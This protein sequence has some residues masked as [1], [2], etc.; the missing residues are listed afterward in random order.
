MKQSQII[1]A[2][3]ALGRLTAQEW[4]VKTA[5]KL[6]LIQDALEPA[7]K[8]GVRM[9]E[10]LIG[11]YGGVET[12]RGTF[13]FPTIDEQKGFQSA[14]EELLDTDATV[15]YSPLMIKDGIPDGLTLRPADM[16]ALDGVVNF[17]IQTE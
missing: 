12:E 11:Q 1:G 5:Y 10:K 17:D 6:M 16:R 15:I 2:Y 8:A 3:M 9:Q 14:L 4:P 13:T 7:Y